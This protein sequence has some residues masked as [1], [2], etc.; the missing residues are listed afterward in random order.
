MHVV[1]GRAHGIDADRR[2]TRALLDRAAN[3]EPAV[4][5]WTPHRQVAFGRRDSRESGY[6]RAVAAARDRGYRAVER[7]V[8]GRAVAYTG[9]TLAFAWARP[10]A[11][12]RSGLSDRY[13]DGIAVVRSALSTVGASVERGEP[14]ESF[15][16]GQHS[17]RA[18]GKVAGI[19]QRVTGGAALIAGC[20]VVADDGAIAA[21]LDPVYEALGVAFDPESVGSVAAAGGPEAPTPVARAI[22]SAIVERSGALGDA[23]DGRRVVDAASAFDAVVDEDEVA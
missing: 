6:G 2:L 1:R 12:A 20:V 17:L 22:E 23:G 15:C 18:S 3:G 13:D 8:G 14:P 5:A 21:V 11:D 19:A 10:V 9:T 16:P 7:S 4:R